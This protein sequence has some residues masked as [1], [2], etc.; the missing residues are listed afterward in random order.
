MDTQR[1]TGAGSLFPPPT[2]QVGD[3]LSLRAIPS[4][5]LEKS[6][7]KVRQIMGCAIQQGEED[8]RPTPLR[9]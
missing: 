1:D 9:F 7:P 6:N 8:A 4:A 2:I 3:R 5:F